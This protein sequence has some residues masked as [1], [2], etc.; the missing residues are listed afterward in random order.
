MLT[1]ILIFPGILRYHTER[2]S[3]NLFPGGS[4]RVGEDA[5]EDES[6]RCQGPPNKEESGGLGQVRRPAVQLQCHERVRQQ[7][8]S[9]V[10]IQQ[11]LMAGVCQ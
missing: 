1:V 5:G 10:R 8:G 4:S 6:Y 11:E 3:S 7:Q 9:F 2:G